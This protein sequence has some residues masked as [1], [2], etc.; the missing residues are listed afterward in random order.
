[1]SALNREDV[2]MYPENQQDKLKVAITCVVNA[3]KTLDDFKIFL[4]TEKYK[5]WNDRQ[6]Q[7]QEEQVKEMIGDTPEG[8]PFKKPVDDDED[9]KVEWLQATGAATEEEAV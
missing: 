2:T 7:V 4:K 9:E 3:E 1:M 6:N 5:E 8:T